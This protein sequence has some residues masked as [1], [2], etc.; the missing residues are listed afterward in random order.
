MKAADRQEL[1]AECE[2]ALEAIRQGT[3]PRDI[4]DLFAWT[5]P[6]NESLTTYAARMYQAEIDYLRG[7]NTRLSL[8]DPSLQG[9]DV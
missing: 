2:T 5:S 8:G 7:V 4:N 6:R 9:W 1:M 3:W